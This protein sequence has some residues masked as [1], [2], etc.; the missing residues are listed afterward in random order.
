MKKEEIKIE[1]K[2]KLE[3]LHW[4][5]QQWKSN[6]RFMDDEIIFINRLL[7]SYAFQPNTPN[8]FE[9]I[10]DFKTRLK[11]VT[12]EKKEVLKQISKHENDLGGMLEC[13]DI[14]CDLGYYR[15]QDKLQAEVDL[16]LENFRQLKS[17]IFNYAGGILKSRKPDNE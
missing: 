5:I 1:Q 13:T 12:T 16:C 11:H 8:L 6:L 4:Q 7:D 3:D 2:K 15:K 14:Q 17:E 9:R 10:Q